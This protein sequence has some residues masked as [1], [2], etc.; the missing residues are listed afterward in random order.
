MR[1]Q[2]QGCLGPCERARRR[3]VDTKDGNRMSRSAL[4]VGKAYLD[5]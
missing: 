2:V 4:R 3:Y 1:V 5:I